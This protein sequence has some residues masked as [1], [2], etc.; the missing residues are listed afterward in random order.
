M[1][2]VCVCVLYLS[3]L[4][5]KKLWNCR[6]TGTYAENEL[7]FSEETAMIYAV[8]GVGLT[9]TDRSAWWARWAGGRA[10]A[11]Q[12]RWEWTARAAET[13]SAPAQNHSTTEGRFFYFY[14]LWPLLCHLWRFSSSSFFRWII[15][16]TGLNNTWKNCRTTQRT[17][18]P[19]AWRREECLCGAANV[20]LRTVC[21]RE[22]THRHLLPTLPT[23]TSCCCCRRGSLFTPSNRWNAHP[24][25]AP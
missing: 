1:C 23:H 19:S 16:C 2:C 4:V 5:H 9:W 20:L 12:E 6:K 14:L 18:Q 15:N 21:V 25:T 11:G 10:S 24:T 8:F 3:I 13:W 22:L 7:T 17:V